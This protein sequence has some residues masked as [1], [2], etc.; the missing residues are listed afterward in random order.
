[1]LIGGFI[2]GER[3]QWFKA[4]LD[5]VLDAFKADPAQRE[6]YAAILRDGG[7]YL[8]S[9]A[10]SQGLMDRFEEMLRAALAKHLDWLRE[11]LGGPPVLPLGFVNYRFHRA[12]ANRVDPRTFVHFHQDRFFVGAGPMVNFWTPLDD[13]GV[14]APGL[15]VVLGPETRDLRDV[16]KAR[17][18]LVGNTLSSLTEE[19]VRE[20]YP[21]REFAHPAMSAGD[22][23]AMH[24]LTPHRTY[25]TK[26]MTKPRASL[27]VRVFREGALPGFTPLLERRL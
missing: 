4:T 1:M 3:T 9:F 23:L 11:F 24:E 7:F 27:E 22:A 17:S 25:A 20:I 13:C 8:G 19:E 14:E 16:A 6:N 5:T 10:S 26:S 15:E 12:V 2:P 18:P 21:D